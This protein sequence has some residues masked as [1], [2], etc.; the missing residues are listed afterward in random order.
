MNA[1]TLHI[2]KPAEPAQAEPGSGHKHLIGTKQFLRTHKGQMVHLFTSV[3]FSV[4]PR[5][6]TVD[7]FLVAQ[8]DADKLFISEE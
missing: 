6:V 8:L 2:N 4:E 5:R 3:V 1:K 7:E